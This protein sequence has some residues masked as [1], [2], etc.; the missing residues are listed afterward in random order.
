MV[1]ELVFSFYYNDLLKKYYSLA[2]LIASGKWLLIF[3]DL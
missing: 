3:T 1:N 2:R